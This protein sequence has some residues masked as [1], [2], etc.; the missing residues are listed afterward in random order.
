MTRRRHA[1]PAKKDRNHDEI[2]RAFR[3]VRGCVVEDCH[4]VGSRCI[5]GWPDLI[6]AWRGRLIP[7]E[8]KVPG[9]GLTA[10]E[11]K[12]H[13]RWRGAGVQVEIVTTAEEA[14]RLLGLIRGECRT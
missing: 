9:E 5:P 2:A 4:E 10:G 13:A 7:V 1:G 14:W 6:V 12:L 3:G 11:E 8:I